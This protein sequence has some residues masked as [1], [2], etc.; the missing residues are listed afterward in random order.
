MNGTPKVAEVFKALGDEHR[1]K[2]LEF[3]VRNDPNCCSTPNGICGCDLQ[4]ISGLAQATVSHHL[5]ILSD[6]GLITGTKRGRWV[7]YHISE[8]GLA[9]ARS[10]LEGFDAPITSDPLPLKRTQKTRV[11]APQTLSSAPSR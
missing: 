11:P 2:M 10:A 9:V 6:A 8:A 5:K 7:Y 3:I 1:L 4:A